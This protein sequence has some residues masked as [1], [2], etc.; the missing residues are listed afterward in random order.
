[1]AKW[2]KINSK[3]ILRT[4]RF[5]IYEDD[6]ILPDSK[7]GKYFYIDTP[8]GVMVIP[9]DGKKFYLVNQHRYVQKKRNWEFPAGRAETK[10]LLLQAKKELGEE[11]GISAK[12][13]SRLGSFS[14]SAGSNTVRGEIF[15]AQN[16]SFGDHSREGSESDMYVQSFT[17]QQLEKMIIN[18]QLDDAW[19]IVCLY[20]FKLRKPKF[21]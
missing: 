20:H 6:V 5:D 3:R 9:F 10:N 13:W 15:L 11:T 14:P 7:A 16:L 21:L 8:P 19:T 18:G 2:K 4:P 12:R 17:L 1:M